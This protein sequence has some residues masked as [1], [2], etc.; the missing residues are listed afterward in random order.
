M[1]DNLSLGKFAHSQLILKLPY[2]ETKFTGKT[3]IVTGANSGL[4]L[5][6]ARHFVRLHASRVILAVRDTSKGE[7][8]LKTIEESTGRRGIIQRWQLDLASYASVESFATRINDTLDRLDIVAQNAGVY[9]LSGF[10]KSGQDEHHITV[11]VVSTMLLALLLLPKLRQTQASTGCEAVMTFTGSWM[12]TLVSKFPEQDA[13]NI[14]AALS[15]FRDG[16]KLAN[17]YAPTLFEP[18]VSRLTHACVDTKSPNSCNC[19]MSAS[20]PRK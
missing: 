1:P 5:E 14:F 16:Q 15:D 6:A 11:N 4:G 13:V 12:H 10:S 19:S 2:P 8:A 17:R 3:V 18:T 9:T 20:L 7:A